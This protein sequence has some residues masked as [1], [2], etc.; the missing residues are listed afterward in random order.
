[1][2][3]SQLLA[4][5]RRETGRVPDAADREAEILVSRV[6]GIPA[7]RLFL[8]M[9]AETGDAAEALAP[10]LAR[11]A[12]GEPLQYV[13]GS[14]DFYGREFLLTRDTLIPR[15]E[16][17]GLVE[18]ALRRRGARV[19]DVGTGCGAIAVTLAAEAPGI[20]VVAT[21]VSAAA[22]RV[23]RE[24]ARRHGVAGRV[25]FARCDAYSA[26][27][28]GDR[29]DVVVSNPPYV[30]EGEWSSLPPAVRDHEP[31]GALLAGPDGLSVLRRLAEGGGG[32]LAPGG[33]LWCE[34]GADQGAAVA[35]L[36]S[37]PLRF[38]GVFR[39]LAGRDRYAGWA[40]PETERG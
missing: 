12:A 37:G 19:L 39:D 18:R 2:R 35:A 6:T 27:K 31:S 23:A 8:S 13:L 1:M 5:C 15:P 9:D 24:N 14:W 25:A 34:I 29:F 17:E 3:L 4:L 26:L 40:K 11:R 32:L 21:D 33:E 16:T 38:L 22:L 36:P 20:R 28:C 10:L 7:G 30:A